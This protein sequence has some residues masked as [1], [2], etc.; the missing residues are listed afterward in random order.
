MD[1]NLNF[2]KIFMGK[3]RI[4]E[5]ELW[6]RE[7]LD[8]VAP[9]MLSL[10]PKGVGQIALIA[11]EAQLDYRVVMRDGLPGIEFSFQGFDEGD[12]VMGRGWALLQ[13]QQLQGRLFF[14]QGD[15]SSFVAQRE[16]LWKSPACSRRPAGT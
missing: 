14:H 7:A 12:E 1:T 10:K 4:T 11:I 3:W 6:D 16:P 8:L 9:A 13:G 2:T 15:D 5:T